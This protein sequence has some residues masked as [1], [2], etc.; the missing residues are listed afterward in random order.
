MQRHKPSNMDKI[1]WARTYENVTFRIG[2]H[3]CS[4]EP[5]QIAYSH[6]GI[7]NVMTE[8]KYSLCKKAGH[9]W[10]KC[11]NSAHAAVLFTLNTV[12][13]GVHA[14][15]GCWNM[16]DTWK[17]F[18]RRFYYLEKIPAK[19]LLPE[20]NSSEYSTTWKNFQRRFYYLKKI[21][22][23]ILLP[24]KNS[25][26]DST[27]W[28]KFQ[29]IFYYLEKF[30]AKIVVPGK[31][32]REDSTTWNIFQLKDSTTW[33]FSSRIFARRYTWKSFQILRWKIF[34]EYYIED[35]SQWNS[36]RRS[37][38]HMKYLNDQ[39]DKYV[40][41]NISTI[42]KRTTT[43]S[44]QQYKINTTQQQNMLLSL[45]HSHADSWLSLLT[46]ISATTMHT[47]AVFEA[48]L[49][50]QLILSL[51]TLYISQSC[52]A[53]D[54]VGTARNE[55]IYHIQLYPFSLTCLWPTMLI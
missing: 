27:T 6:F 51:L 55:L 38:G 14:Q 7:N 25:S 15:N 48:Q 8:N 40:L 44:Q 21:Q 2:N 12:C 41:T 17:M 9:I 10:V 35:A 30:P 54:K 45:R 13:M 3:V 24:E 32:S 47:V 29:R 23:K 42:M 33:K 52:V 16:S 28:K 5:L 53:S 49:C 31:F 20:K 1:C 26:E 11:A 50:G 19:I 22:A 4:P 46:Y 37:L 39:A 18:Q 36:P 34:Q 43:K